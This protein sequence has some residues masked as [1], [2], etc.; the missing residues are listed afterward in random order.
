M[1]ICC[2]Y[3]L[4]CAACCSPAWCCRH[5]VSLDAIQA[6]E[7]LKGRLRRPLT[8]RRNR[9]VPCWHGWHP[10]SLLLLWLLLRPQLLLLQH[11]S[12]PFLG[13]CNT[14]DDYLIIVRV[15]VND[16]D[17]TVSSCCWRTLL[18]LLLLLSRL[19]L[20]CLLQLAALLLLL[21]LLLL[22]LLLRLLWWA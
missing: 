20:L 7:A 19:R 2:C 1:H 10:S 17:I 14:C 3:V 12:R 16:D 18:L 13:Q 21:I 5:A 8:W 22:V 15:A 6:D 11:L 9:R 4:R